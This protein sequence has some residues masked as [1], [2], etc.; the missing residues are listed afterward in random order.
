MSLYNASKTNEE[1]I[2]DT[3]LRWRMFCL[4]LDLLKREPKL[5]H[6]LKVVWKKEHFLKKN[7]TNIP[8]SQG[9]YMFVL[10]V[11]GKIPINSTSK[12]VLY[13]GKARNLKTRYSSYFNYE[14]KDN[15]SD[16]LKKIMTVVWKGKL[17]FHFFD[18]ENLSDVDLDKI[19]MDL[20]DSLAPPM[21]QRFRGRIL[22][23]HIKLYAP[24]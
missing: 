2:A 24:R 10:N 7:K 4:D 17:E 6:K 12:Y 5:L 9:I 16:L 13:V 23:G 11:E 1:L 14:K 22:K 21:N 8:N 19:E 20:I 3:R 18:S 15:P